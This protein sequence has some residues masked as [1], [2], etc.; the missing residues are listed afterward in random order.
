LRQRLSSPAPSPLTSTTSDSGSG[1]ASVTYQL[2]PAN[3]NL[4]EPGHRLNTTGSPDG[5]YDLRVIAVDNAGNSTP[6]P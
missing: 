4:D 3:T 6:R 2:S 5:H 1:I